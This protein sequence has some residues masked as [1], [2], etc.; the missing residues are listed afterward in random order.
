M[1]PANMRVTDAWGN[2]SASSLWWLPG[3][4]PN[5]GNVRRDVKA[6]GKRELTK[7]GK[8]ANKYSTIKKTRELA[9]AG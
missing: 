5:G 2:A 7:P 9:E 4:V 6:V 3:L 8:R 1:N